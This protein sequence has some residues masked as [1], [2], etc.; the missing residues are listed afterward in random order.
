MTGQ[1]FVVDR[2]M[3]WLEDQPAQAPASLLGEVLADVSYAPQA[4][5]RRIALPRPEQSNPNVLRFAAVLLAVFVVGAGVAGWSAWNALTVGPI[6]SPTPA[7]TIAPA[8]SP[9]PTSRAETSPKSSVSRHH[10]RQ[11]AT[12]PWSPEAAELPWPGPMRTEPDPPSAAIRWYGGFAD[13]VGDIAGSAPDWMDISEVT[14]SG[15]IGFLMDTR[16][17][18]AGLEFA[19]PPPAETWVAYGLVLDVDGDRV[20]D[21]QIGIDN[22]LLRDRVTRVD[23]RSRHG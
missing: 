20:A 17:P 14:T 19:M 9:T 8:V 12:S 1:D 7:P 4:T 3:M 13:T 11:Q 2:L 16:I 22:A 15:G 6:T 21:Q 10:L 5:R 23:H 18:L